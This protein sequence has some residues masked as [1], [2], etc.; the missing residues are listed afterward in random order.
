MPLKRLQKPQYYHLDKVFS[1]F[2]ENISELQFW[3]I[4]FPG[5]FLDH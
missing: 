3:A 2:P 5:G 4:N 1:E